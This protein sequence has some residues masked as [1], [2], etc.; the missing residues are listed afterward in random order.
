[1]DENV[2][3]V[4]DRGRDGETESVEEVVGCPVVGKADAFVVSEEVGECVIRGG[5]VCWC[6]Q[7]LEKRRD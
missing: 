3:V 6:F 1:M 7:A 4:G 2:D 5:A